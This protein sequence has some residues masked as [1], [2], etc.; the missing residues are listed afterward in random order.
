MGKEDTTAKYAGNIRRMSFSDLNEVAGIHSESFPGFFLTFLGKK[1]LSLYYRD[2][3]KSKYGLSLVFEENG[4]I[5]GFITGMRSPK[6]FYADF[7]KDHW[8]ELIIISF[9]AIIKKPSAIYKLFKGF[10]Y[11]KNSSAGGNTMNLSSVA[12]LPEMQ[13]KGTGTRLVEGFLRFSREIN[14]DRVILGVKKTELKTIKFYE[15]MQ[16]LE[17]KNARNPISND[18]IILYKNLK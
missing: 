6:Y 18:S 10:L 3:S 15:K 16:F 4:K 1:F 8:P 5:V 12:V 9:K 7:I 2:V 17:D 14:V 11:P 13:G